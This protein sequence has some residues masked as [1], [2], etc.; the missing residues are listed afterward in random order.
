M[1]HRSSI[2]VRYCT[3]PG[4]I[5]NGQ[6]EGDAPFTCIS[7]VKYT[8]NDGFWLLGVDTLRCEIDGQWDYGKPVCIDK[9]EKHQQT[10]ILKSVVVFIFMKCNTYLLLFKIKVV[11]SLQNYLKHRDSAV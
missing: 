8:C 3:D 7:T 2:S 6:K 9:S 1:C 5:E 10:Y 4:S 11:E